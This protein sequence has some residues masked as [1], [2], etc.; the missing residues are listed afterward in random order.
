MLHIHTPIEFEK[1]IDWHES[2]GLTRERMSVQQLLDSRDNSDMLIT[3]LARY[4]KS[5]EKIFLHVKQ[6]QWTPLLKQPTFSWS[7][8]GSVISSTAWNFEKNNIHIALASIHVEKGYKHIEEQKYKE[9]SKQFNKAMEQYIFAKKTLHSWKWKLPSE[10]YFIVQKS[11]QE[12]QIEKLKCLQQLC[13]L[14]VGIGQNSSDKTLYTVAQRATKHAALEQVHSPSELSLL[15]LCETLRYLYSSNIQWTNEEYGA[16]IDTLQRWVVPSET[17]FQIINEE[18]DKLQ[19]L[20]NER[21]ITNDNVYYNSVKP[22]N[23]LPSLCE[24]IESV[25]NLSHP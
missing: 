2:I 14:S 13:T 3:R 22:S 11:W 17:K 15:H 7:I 20:L 1:I 19:L 4:S 10:N 18:F 5:F 23:S 12:A 6:N 21:K 9:A 24:I 8:D 25:N 16:S